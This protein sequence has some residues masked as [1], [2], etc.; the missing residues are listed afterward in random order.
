MSSGGLPPV[1]T[2]PR[3]VFVTGTD[4][5]VGKTI[6]T[7]ALAA[8][9]L[10]RGRTV[11]VYK[12]VQAGVE[13]GGGDIDRVRSFTGIDD[14]HEGI[15]LVHPMAPVAAAE[16]EGVTLP[17]AEAHADTINQLADTHDHTLVEG[18]GGV[19]VQL[20]EHGRTLADIAGALGAD[21]AGA[22]VVC[23]AAL[24]TLNHTELTL[25]ALQRRG[26]PVAGLVIGA[27]P[28]EPDEINISNRRYLNGHEVA[29][30]GGIPEGAARLDP[31]EFR[32]AVPRWLRL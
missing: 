24:G 25:E 27:W 23:R 12:P 1:T 14:V 26:V 13:D 28:R 29:L 31:A 17:S 4:T 15:R 19:L 7:A 32:A 6:A 21:A 5:G 8:A 3:I 9:L 30:L 20:D 18:A 16:R 22:I 11:A 2:V 10:A